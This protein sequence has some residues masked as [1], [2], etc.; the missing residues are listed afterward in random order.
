[1][2]RLEPLRRF[3]GWEQLSLA[4]VLTRNQGCPRFA[5]TGRDVN[6]CCGTTN[7]G[8]DYLLPSV[9]VFL[10]LILQSGQLPAFS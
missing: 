9:A 10:R 8:A 3:P 2:K 1:V 4:D 6:H 5:R 7:P